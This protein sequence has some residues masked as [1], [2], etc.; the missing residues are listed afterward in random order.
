KFRSDI[1]GFVT[2]VRF[3]K[4]AAN[5][6]AHVGHLWSATGVLLA[7]ATFTNESVSG[8]QEV[9]LTPPVAITANTTYIASYHADS[10]FFAID[11]GFFS[12][13]G[14]DSPPLHALQ[15]GVDGADGVFLYG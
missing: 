5:T 14:V 6:G 9:T 13:M 15:A 1:N 4:G 11:T 12:A 7:E 3:F 8:W 10:G 2:A